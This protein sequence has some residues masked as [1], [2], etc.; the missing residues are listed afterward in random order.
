MKPQDKTTGI[1]VWRCN[2]IQ[3]SG[4]LWKNPVGAYHCNKSKEFMPLR[5]YSL[6][7]IRDVNK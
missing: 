7:K 4:W 3:A 1:R 5:G 2:D 6:L